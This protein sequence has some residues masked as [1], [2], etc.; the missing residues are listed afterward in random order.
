MS[1]S[2]AYREIEP[3]AALAPF[4]RCLWHLSGPAS[5][6]HESQP[7]VPDG[8]VEIVLNLADP[9]IRANGGIGV[10]PAAMFVGQHTGPVVVIPTGLID[11]WGVR[12]HP[13]G[14]AGLI[15]IP[16]G[17]L[18]ES[19][20]ELEQVLGRRADLCGDLGD[21]GTE[22]SAERALMAALERRLSGRNPPE[23]GTR[24]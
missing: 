24:A 5:T 21:H 9:F 2:I 18:R 4:V 20:V 7:I 23:R 17:E 19:T 13:W 16:L 12:L 6:A 1:E 22:A 15:E 11:V 14:A 3:S 8:C 10:Q